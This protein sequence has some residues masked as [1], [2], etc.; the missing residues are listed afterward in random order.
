M[1]DKTIFDLKDAVEAWAWDEYV[2]TENRKQRRLRQKEEKNPNMYVG[3]N[4]DWSNVKF[5]DESQWP[6]LLEASFDDD[7]NKN[8]EKQPLNGADSEEPT[9][10]VTPV[11]DVRQ[12]AQHGE[13]HVS[14]LFNTKFT[15]STDEDQEY[16]IKT[17]K[18]TR[19]ECTTEIENSWSRSWEMGI[20]LKTPCEIFEANA[21]YSRE[22]S[23][24]NTQGQ[25]FEEELNW[26]VESLIKVKA[27]HVAEASLVVNEKKYSGDFLV[28]SR[29]QGMVYITFTNHRDN[30]AL[31]KATG[32]EIAAIVSWYILR[33]RRK[34]LSYPYVQV[35]GDVVKISTKGSCNFRFGINQEVHVKQTPIA[36]IE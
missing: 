16:T 20:S 1:P 15:N 7:A 19:S 4:I 21:G 29:I 27:K 14:T 23:L 26:G 24:T 11:Y 3:V 9:Q 36:P 25:T 2:S 5:H 31:I 10:A 32:E 30:N 6:R 28:E 17:E 8:K 12:R 33:Q 22:V 35:D 18:T 13:T 34:S